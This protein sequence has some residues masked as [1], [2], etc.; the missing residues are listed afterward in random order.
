MH[1]SKT[2]KPLDSNATNVMMA[3]FFLA[4]ERLI[5]R[6]FTS[7]LCSL[8]RGNIYF[9]GIGNETGVKKEKFRN[10]KLSD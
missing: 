5:I 8:Q 9:A 7:L 4:G 2:E 1:H 6:Y 10:E 3:S